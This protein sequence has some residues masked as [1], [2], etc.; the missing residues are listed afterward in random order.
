M[1][2]VLEEIK[3]LQF[4]EMVGVPNLRGANAVSRDGEEIVCTLHG[5]LAPVGAGSERERT[6]ATEQH[7][8]G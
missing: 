2:K 1:R 8:A 5:Q 4:K 7:A 3:E 6:R